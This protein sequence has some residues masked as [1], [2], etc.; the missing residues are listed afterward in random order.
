MAG[1]KRDP[2]VVAATLKRDQYTCR[3]CGRRQGSLHV[4]HIVGLHE[5][6][7]DAT[8]NTETLCEPCHYEWESVHLATTMSY[9]TW[10]TLPP[11]HNL[12]ALLSNADLWR[13][14]MSAAEFRRYVFHVA[15]MMR[16]MRQMELRPDEPG[17]EAQMADDEGVEALLGL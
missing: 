14:D 16:D 7:V 12:L 9:D 10:M 11:A 5:G 6:G 3:R 1:L 8:F 4:N 17:Y 15:Q 2:K 13:P